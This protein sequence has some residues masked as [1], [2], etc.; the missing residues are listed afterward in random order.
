V[1]GYDDDRQVF[2]LSADPLQYLDAV[3]IRHPHVEQHQGRRPALDGRDGIATAVHRN[4]VESL[5]TENSLDRMDHT[6]IVVD[7][8]DALAPR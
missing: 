2:S 8:E 3:E 7:D 5:V 4:D 1:P 6:H